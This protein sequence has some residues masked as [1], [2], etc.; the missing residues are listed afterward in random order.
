MVRPV[1]EDAGTPATTYS[2]YLHLVMAR[3]M[4][5]R[6]QADRADLA[7]LHRALAAA[8]RRGVSV[9]RPQM[10]CAAPWHAGMAYALGY[11]RAG[12]RMIESGA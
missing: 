1:L 12:L 7:D 9:R 2:F 11:I 4:R 10:A 8:T 5:N 6:Y 3:V